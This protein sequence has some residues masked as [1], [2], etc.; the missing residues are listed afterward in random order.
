MK[1]WKSLVLIGI[2]VAGF[3]TIY[4]MSTQSK[5]PAPAPAPQVANAV[6]EPRP[7]GYDPE[8]ILPPPDVQGFVV[9]LPAK[10]VRDH[11]VAMAG[12]K[13]P[14][15]VEQGLL[16]IPP[17]PDELIPV[18]GRTVVRLPAPFDE[19]LGQIGELLPMPA[20]ILPMPRELP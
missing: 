19:P 5:K 12:L 17:S 9:D 2:I 16:T 15:D 10:D 18:E 7:A 1:T 4:L 11:F 6:E 14:K 20:E 8:L 13:L 3:G